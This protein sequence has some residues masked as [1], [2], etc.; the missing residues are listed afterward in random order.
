M[1]HLSDQVCACGCGERT[2]LIAETNSR[3]GRRR[4]EPNRYRVGHNPVGS[5]KTRAGWDVDGAGCWIWNGCVHPL[6]YGMVRRDGRNQMAHRYVY[7]RE[8]GALDPG[9]HLHHRCGVR[10]CVNPAHLE[11]LTSTEHL[12]LQGKLTMDGA[13]E[14]RTLAACGTSQS[15][16]ARRFAVSPRTIRD[17]LLGNTW[18]ES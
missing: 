5:R 18:R 13:R 3:R 15:E 17:V 7:E 10:A 14:I 6:G 8:R 9:L 11:P 2:T 4:G 1:S 16:L 12:R